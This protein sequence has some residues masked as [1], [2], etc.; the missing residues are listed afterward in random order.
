MSGFLTVIVPVDGEGAGEAPGK[1][2]SAPEIEF[3]K[4]CAKNLALRSYLTIP[5]LLY[6]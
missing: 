6:I 5:S 2:A 4:G 1:C 3:L